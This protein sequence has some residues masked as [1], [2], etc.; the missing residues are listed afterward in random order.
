MTAPALPRSLRVAGVVLAVALAFGLLLAVA[1]IGW[2]GV[3]GAIAADYLRSAKNSAAEVS[4]SLSDPVVAADAIAEAA[5]KAAVAHALTSD[6]VWRVVEL[7]PWV[8]PQLVAV[9]TVA[10][11][12]DEI[13]SD[14]LGPLAEVASTLSPEMFRPKGG[15]VD[16]GGFVAVQDAAARAAATMDSATAGLDRINTAA[17]VAP[18]RSIV[19]EVSST[20]EEANDA[21]TALANASTLIPA[22][23]GADG[24]RN[25]LV[26]FQNNA[27]WRSLGGIAGAMVVVGTEG[28]SMR[29]VANDAATGFISTDTS[30]I[31]LSDEVTAIYGDRPGKW[32][33]NVT[34]V[35]DFAVSAELARAMWAN[36]HG[37]QVDGVIATDPVALSY[38]LAA[39]GPVIL[40][41]GDKLTADNA[42]ALLM[43]D[44]Y[45]RYPDPADQD[46]FFADA[47]S[48]V[49]GALTGGAA[50]PGKLLTALGKAGDERRL[51]LWSSHSEDQDVLAD[52]TLA[53]G[54]PVTDDAT[55]TFGVFLN[56]ATGAKLDYYQTVDT[57]VEWQTCAIDASGKAQGTAVLTVD[58]TDNAPA[59]AANLPAYVTGGGWFGVPVGTTRT[60]GYLYVPEGFELVD[61]TL[62]TG[63]GFG[64]GVHDG[65]RVL[66]FEFDLTPGTSATATVTARSVTPTGANLVAQVTPT[67]NA[68]VTAPIS[69][70]L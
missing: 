28:G 61:A 12:A 62:S 43:N 14:A 60:V 24:P 10:A 59:D 39:T 36:K 13:A 27:E 58:L 40:P 21:T 6:P 44:V 26:L 56:D 29:L 41:S 46:A 16:L 49:F 3:R 37:V 38:I 25:Y 15:T 55:S 18:L 69:A 45:L 20:F 2:V 52:T 32:M 42:V 1:A 54:L 34:Q 31:P 7:T 53:G 57:A 5:E 9:S 66:S 35:P 50:D 30:V 51:L 8:G 48:A 17:L 65:R 63:G 11:S 22:M 23:L 70:C 67:V 4:K 19:E 47:T 33:Q 64:G 68:N